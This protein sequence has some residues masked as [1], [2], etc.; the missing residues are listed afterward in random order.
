MVR[1]VALLITMIGVTAPITT[2]ADTIILK[3]G[4]TISGEYLGETPTEIKFKSGNEKIV[5]PKTM[6]DRIRRD[7]VVVRLLNGN[8]VIAKLME[9]TEDYVKLRFPYGY[10]KFSRDEIESVERRTIEEKP[11]IWKPSRRPSRCS[12]SQTP[13]MQVN[14]YAHSIIDRY[15]F[16]P[17]KISLSKEEVLA[18]H[19]KV[20]QYFQK[21]Q[22]RKAAELLRK[23]IEA[24]PRDH[25]AW[26]NLACA[27]SLMHKRKDAVKALCLAVK[28]GFTDFMH[29]SHDPDLNNI[30]NRPEYRRL[31]D[32]AERIMREG[33]DRT[34]QQLKK[35]FG[36]GYT[37]YI[38]EERRLI[39][40]TNRS[41][42]VIQRMKEHLRALADAEWADFFE[43]K[44]MY[45]ISVV[46]PSRRDFRRLV[47]DPR[48]G[49]FYN[50]ANKILI[51]SNIG[52]VLDHEFTHAMH[53]ADQHARMQQHPIW[54]CEGYATLMEAAHVAGGHCLPW[55]VNPRLRVIQDAVRTAR[56]IPWSRFMKLS[57]PQFM[58]ASGLCYA[59]ARYI[60]LF[61]WEKKILRKWYDH[62]CRN[63][64]KDR[65]G[66]QALEKVTGRT[67]SQLEREWKQWVMSIRGQDKREHR[68]AGP[69][70]GI[71]V[72]EIMTG[73]VITRVDES[74]AARRRLRAGDMI[75]KANGRNVR[76][77]SELNAV[78]R[79]V[80]RGGRVYFRILRKLPKRKK[81]AKLN[82]SII[83]K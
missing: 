34:V 62:F 8:Q 13:G 63:W 18:M 52:Y 82:V 2:D 22:F 23:I 32:E 56:S 77:L 65:T 37:Y 47:R 16:P 31:M 71:T 4:K 83:V 50:P 40:A 68:P 75:L 30:R 51:C 21:K 48:I 42:D 66:T 27:Y 28:A 17:K 78:L 69:N 61:L 33:A 41:L 67:L 54:I 81:P 1:S 15:E 7:V 25:I 3:D 45:Y 58:R 46:C 10:K 9:E 44:P 55:R 73:I 57:Q 49:G 80:R 38:D 79:R 35:Q 64:K 26:Y 12:D 6:I 70:L 59:Q 14:P 53:F 5:L 36:E 72:A 43:H 24:E 19:R 20:H 60:M 29:I 39:F 11:K 76:T 74:G